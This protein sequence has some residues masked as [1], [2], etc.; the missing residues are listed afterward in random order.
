MVLSSIDN[1]FGP[2]SLNEPITPPRIK[3]KNII[4][5]IPAMNTAKKL[6]QNIFPK[7]S[8]GSVGLFSDIIVVLI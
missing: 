6:G 1:G 7:V 2:K 4:P 5:T 3:K 8:L